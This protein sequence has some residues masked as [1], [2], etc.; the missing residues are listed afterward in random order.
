MKDAN[1]N[2][3]D[4]SLADRDPDYINREF[5]SLFLWVQ[6]RVGWKERLTQQREVT[7]DSDLL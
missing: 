5:L 1:N 4:D 3:K 7:L 2:T 6:E